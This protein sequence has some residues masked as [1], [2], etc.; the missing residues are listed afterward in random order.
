M[1]KRL[2]RYWRVYKRDLYLM[3]TKQQVQNLDVFWS[4]VCKTVA[5]SLCVNHHKDCLISSAHVFKDSSYHNIFKDALQLRFHRQ[6]HAQC[7]FLFYPNITKTSRNNPQKRAQK[8]LLTSYML[9]ANWLHECVIRGAT[10]KTFQIHNRSAGSMV[11]WF[12]DS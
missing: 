2:H 7:R 10:A 9:N 12:L 6:R 11:P 8:R 4:L 1:P 5:N 3:S